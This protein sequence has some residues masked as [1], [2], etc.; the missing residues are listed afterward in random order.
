M[1]NYISLQLLAF[2]AATYMYMY[3]YTSEYDILFFIQRGGDLLC[4]LRYYTSVAGTELYH[5]VINC[6]VSVVLIL[7]LA[8]SQRF[9]RETNQTHG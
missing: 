6:D 9:H 8:P 7:R 4:K 3:M 1:Y 5:H 2:T